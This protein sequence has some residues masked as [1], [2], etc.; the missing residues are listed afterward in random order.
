MWKLLCPNFWGFFPNFQRIKTFGGAHSSPVP[1]LLH[2]CSKSTRTM[3]RRRGLLAA[4][5]LDIVQWE[6]CPQHICCCENILRKS[7]NPGLYDLGKGIPGN[8]K[9]G[10][11]CVVDAISLFTFAFVQS[12]NSGITI[13]FGKQFFHSNTCNE[14]CLSVWMKDV[15]RVV[16]QEN[17]HTWTIRWSII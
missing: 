1:Q 4:L 6:D 9:K 12:D 16:E 11:F 5:L 10:G 3:C 2:C 8:I 7:L 17:H 14:Y 15:F 13:S